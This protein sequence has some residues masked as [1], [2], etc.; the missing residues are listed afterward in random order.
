MQATKI[1]VTWSNTIKAFTIVTSLLFIVIEYIMMSRLIV[2]YDLLPLSVSLF[3][4]F[5]VVSFVIRIPLY[6]S[7]NEDGLLLKRI[8]GKIVFSY[9]E[10]AFVDRFTSIANVKLYGSGGFMGDLG[11]YSN[12]DFG[13]YHSYVENRKEAF[14]IIT[15]DGK[16]FVLSCP[17]PTLMIDMIRQKCNSMD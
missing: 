1:K 7:L 16:K 15:K 3:I 6:I 11:V 10:I 13:I 8:V 5:I 9:H 4:L 17:N 14:I 2:H 12:R